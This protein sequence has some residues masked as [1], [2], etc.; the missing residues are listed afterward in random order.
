MKMGTTFVGL[1]VLGCITFAG[2]FVTGC[3]FDPSHRGKDQSAE[4]ARLQQELNSQKYELQALARRCGVSDSNINSLSATGLISEIKIKLGNSSGYY[5]RF[6]SDNDLA[7]LKDLL[8][9]EPQLEKVIRDYD[10]FMKQNKGKRIVV[11]P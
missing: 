3:C 2:L 9:D 1:C 5:G 7:K 11:L 6:L 8:A 10:S 4:V